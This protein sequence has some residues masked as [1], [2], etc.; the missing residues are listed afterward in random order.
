MVS[1]APERAGARSDLATGILAAKCLL[2]RSS[3]IIDVSVRC[4]YGDDT[5]GE[6]LVILR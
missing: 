4:G 1:V 3:G 6:E 5:I 2:A